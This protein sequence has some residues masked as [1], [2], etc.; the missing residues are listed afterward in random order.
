[1]KDVVILGRP[2]QL[3][4]RNKA[5]MK[6][7]TIGDSL[8]YK[9]YDGEYHGMSLLFAEPKGKVAAPRSLSITASNLTSLFQRPTVFLLSACPAYERQRLIDKDVYFVVSDKYVHLP[10]LLANE[11]IRKTK[12]AKSLTPVAQYLLLYHLQIGS[13]EGL[14][15]RDIEDKLP[16]SY[17][18]ITLGIT[19]LEDLALCQKVPDGSKRKVI[20]FDKNG[21]NLWEQA[22]PL[23]I[24]PVE[25]RLFC[26]E[27]LSEGHFPTCGINALAHYTM[28]NP[29]PEKII[30]MTVKQLRDFRTS[31]A[32]VRPNEYD[33]NI[34]I[35]AWKYPPV[36][37]MD[38]EI[39]W[40]D[41]LSLAI[42]LRE[43]S[44]PRVEGEVERLIND[45][46]WKD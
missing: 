10:M 3:Q 26:D 6:G 19:C 46:E 32:L 34:I 24:N 4:E 28:L 37:S 14:A 25:E 30:M 38:A 27:L 33:G 11:R 43:D 7:V 45:I 40:V 44:D 21:K 5:Q 13:L 31:G 41:R 22:Q 36:T 2:V 39:E 12:L 35:E 29:D 17:A 18:S 1:M 8:A 42:S 9:F 16:Y 23:L 20:H 15:A